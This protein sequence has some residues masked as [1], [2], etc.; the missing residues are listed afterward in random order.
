VSVRY[1][2]WF[3]LAELTVQRC[4]HGS[5]ADTQ[6][7]DESS[8]ENGGD[9][10]RSSSLHDCSDDGEDGSEDQVVAATD[11]VSNEAGAQSSYETT[12]L[13][14]GNNV[15]LKVGECNTRDFGETISALK[16]R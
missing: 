3:V 6:T 8:Y 1:A 9:V 14:G 16:F 4:D 2:Q 11:P 12:A 7:S 10:T 13:Q 15:G 5:S